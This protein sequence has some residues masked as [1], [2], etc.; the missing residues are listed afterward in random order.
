MNL[1]FIKRLLAAA[2]PA[3]FAAGNAHADAP[4]NGATLYANSCSGCHGNAP[5]TSN[6][7]KI[8]NGRNARSVIDSAIAGDTG[9]MGSLRS[10]FPAGSSAL[11]DVAAYLGNTPAS[12]SFS[13]TAVGSTATAQTLTVYASLKTGSSL[14]GIGIATTGDFTRSGGTCATTLGTGLSCTVLVSFTPTAA[15]AAR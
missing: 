15:G 7:N 11:A 1:S 2:L 12:L 13:A 10:A 3:P 14:S 6:L 4:A 5:L 9:G 8:Y